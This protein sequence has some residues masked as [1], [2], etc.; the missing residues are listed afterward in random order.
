MVSKEARMLR[1]LWM[2]NQRVVSDFQT[3][4]KELKGDK[5]LTFGT[6]H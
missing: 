6:Y 3:L 1:F 2:W 4:N 5:I